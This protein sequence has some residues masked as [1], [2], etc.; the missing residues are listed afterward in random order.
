MDNKKNLW[1][2]TEDLLYFK[3]EIHPVPKD[4]VYQ[5]GL[6]GLQNLPGSSGS[7]DEHTLQAC[8]SSPR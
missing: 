4:V 2:T 6:P 7:D 1:Q 8:G 5:V 3:V